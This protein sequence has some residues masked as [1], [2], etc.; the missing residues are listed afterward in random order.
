[1]KDMHVSG[2]ISKK[3][4]NQSEKTHMKDRAQLVRHDIASVLTICLDAGNIVSF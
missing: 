3:D 4:T 2:E 1:M